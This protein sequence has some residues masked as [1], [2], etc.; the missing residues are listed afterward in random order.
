M[1][2]KGF[3]RNL[4]P[5]EALTPEQVDAV[6]RRA[7]TI[8]S[9]TGVRIEH[10]RALK[11]LEEHGCRVDHD[12]MRAR[13]PEALVEECLRKCPSSFR[14]RARDPDNDLV[15]GG[16][17]IHFLPFC[18]MQTVDIDTW[19]PRMA[20]MQEYIAGVK[21]LDALDHVSAFSNYTPYYGFQGVPPAMAILEGL[22]L[23]MAY[24]SKPLMQEGSSMGC[25]RFVIQ[26]A[27][28]VGCEIAG[29]PNG[30]A[31]LAFYHETIETL[32]RHAEAGLPLG[33]SG[34]GHTMGAT[35]PV[36]FA[37][38]LVLDLAEDMALLALSQLVK[39]GTRVRLGVFTFPMNMQT[40]SPAFGSI[41]NSIY[42]VARFQVARRYRFP[43]GCGMPG[44][45]NSKRTDFQCGYEK[46]MMALT[47]ALSGANTV[48]FHGGINGELTFHP[49]QAI[50]DDDIVGMVGRLLEGFE[51]NEE[52]LASDLIEKVGPI[53]GHYLGTEHTRKWW[54]SENFLPQAADW[55]TYADWMSTGKKSCL[56]YARER[57]EAILANHEPKTLTK[58]QTADV[59]GILQEARQFYRKEGLISKEEWKTYME[60][61]DSPDYPYR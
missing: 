16:N 48:V 9:G 5:L 24:T 41:A 50:L 60:A 19:E 55:L 12:D 4:R 33:V 36:T 35:G 22:G 31:P 61:L 18:G 40:G 11:L 26:M 10:R 49:I 15:L 23:R 51:V 1:V 21:V 54:R 59:A 30:S 57:L 8:L 37:G 2:M 38:S 32:F 47:A 52:T 34:G 3:M 45:S 13:F 39:P 43:V 53:P 42:Q 46:A 6:Y 27:Q 28:A 58:A 17:T 29:S 25:D 20:T 44:A 14:Q 56:S 7:L